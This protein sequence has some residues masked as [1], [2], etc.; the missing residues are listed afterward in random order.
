MAVTETREIQKENWLAR[1]G[2]SFKGMLP[3]L[4]L[5]ILGFPLLV[6]NENRAVS[7]ARRLAQGEGAVR[8]VAADAVNPEN[9]GKLVHVSGMAAVSGAPLADAE[10]GITLPAIRLARN[11]EI[12][13][14]VEHRNSHVEKK[15]GKEVE[16]TTYSYSREWCDDPVD[17]SEFKEEGHNNATR[18]AFGDDEWMAEEVRLGA[19]VLSADNVRSISGRRNLAVPAD[20]ALPAALAGAGA[21]VAGGAIYVPVAPP[22][23][24]PEGTNAAPAA[25]RQVVAQP[26]I[27]DLRVTF[28]SIAPH[29]VSI[30]AQQAGDSFRP[31]IA[32]DGKGLMLQQDGIVDAASMFQSAKASNKL[33]AWLLRLGGF[34]LMFLGLRKALAPLA[35]LVDVIP[36][37]R[38]IISAGVSL[39][40]FLLALAFSLVTI[41]IAWIAFRPL[42]SIPLLVVAAVLVFLA[43]RKRRAA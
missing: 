23:P 11:V 4:L 24:A 42:L 40:A 27:G 18:P 5:F 28:T 15:D 36:M 16:V 35:V 32:K 21:Q 14:W 19:F 8:S 41:A 1:M 38:T 2:A 25:V 31:W 17:S 3:G 13:Q 30:V 34:L 9:E 43:F 37:V 29:D 7:T 20:L 33:L 12:F 22:S 39:V 6:W 26:A 10:F